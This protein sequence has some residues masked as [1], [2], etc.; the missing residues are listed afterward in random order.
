MAADQK[1]TLTSGKVVGN[2][3]NRQEWMVRRRNKYKMDKFGCIEGEM[4]YRDE[5][6]FE[7]LR[8]E[9]EEGEVDGDEDQAI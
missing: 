4:E 2:K 5:N 3:K 9:K 8:E 6:A 7:A 1:R